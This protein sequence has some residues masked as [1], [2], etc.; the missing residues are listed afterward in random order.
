VRRGTACVN[1]H[2]IS[3]NRKGRFSQQLT[4]LCN[5]RATLPNL[6]LDLGGER[7]MLQNVSEA[8]TVYSLRFAGLNYATRVRKAGG[9]QQVALGQAFRIRQTIPTITLTRNNGQK[10]TFSNVSDFTGGVKPGTESVSLNF[11]KIEGSMAGYQDI[12]YQENP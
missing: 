9:T 10:W 1:A 12:A 11:G 7:H 2:T 5:Q 4:A 8:F 6:T 3:L